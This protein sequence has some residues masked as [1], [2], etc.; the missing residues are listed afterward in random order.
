MP[1]RVFSADQPWPL[2]DGAHTRAI[3]ARALAAAPA[4]ALMDRAGL[5]VARLALAVAP[6]ARRVVV[7]A[8]PG[9]NGGDGLI[10]AL[11]LHRV[12]KAVQ[13]LHLA[14]AGR[15][16]ADAAHALQRAKA[17]GVPVTGGGG[18][19]AEADLLIDGL[20]GLGASRPP[21]QRLA[22]AIRAAHA[23]GR[24]VLAID[25]PTGLQADTGCR[26]G[27]DA[28]RATWTLSLLTLKPGLFTAM[29]RDH[30]GDVWFDDLGVTADAPAQAWLS[31]ACSAPY[32]GFAARQHAQHKGSFGDLTVV[33]GAAGM[34]GAAVLAA[35]AALTA[36]AGRVYV[37]LLG[38]APAGLL[39]P[40]LMLS[41]A[42]WLDDAAALGRSTVVCGCGGGQP[43]ADALPRLL[44]HAGRLVLDADALNAIAASPALQAQLQGRAQR[45]AATVLTPHPLEAAR[46]LACDTAAVQGDRLSAATRLAD[47]FA[48]TVVL[49]GSGT[50]MAA[51]GRSPWINASGNAALAAPG[52]GDVLAGW[53]GGLW[54]QQPD[55]SAEGAWFAARASAWLH[56]YAAD[57]LWATHPGQASLPLR[58]GQL[59]GL[60]AAA[61]G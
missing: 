42:G 11:H 17:A 9:N 26:L 19:D 3:E 4:H 36:G 51:P 61:L 33:G 7:L 30:A 53:I 22:A 60:M 48:A 2:H 18:I 39:P 13:V 32:P 34:Q 6:H 41:A 25:L 44:D 52:T 55:R 50:V 27:D 59:P 8:G 28:I 54:A 14:D 57:R 38:E 21:D 35:N 31:A 24:P 10:A 58:A 1:K 40:E 20:L 15:L 47:R 45:G 37:R 43:V 49:K 56:G 46:L 5:A 16:P 29:G 23:T 12:G